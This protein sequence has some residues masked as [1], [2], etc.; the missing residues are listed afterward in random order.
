MNKFLQTRLNI[1]QVLLILLILLSFIPILILITQSVSNLNTVEN[2]SNKT[3]ESTVKEQSIRTYKSYAQNLARRITDFLYSC[4]ADLKTLS[5]LPPAPELYLQFSNDHQRFVHSL[6]AN[7]P[8]Y[9]EISL[10]N[11][12]GQEI[13]KVVDNRLLSEAQLKNVR[14]P[15]NTT[16]KSETYF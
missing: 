5:K 7:I 10:I 1:F 12:S 4:E 11:Q 13:I 14:Y 16:F 2:L 3:I 15:K 6:G 8:I 9:K